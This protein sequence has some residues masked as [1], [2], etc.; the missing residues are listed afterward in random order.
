PAGVRRRIRRSPSASWLAISDALD[1]GWRGARHRK[2]RSPA[3][4]TPLAKVRQP[5]ATLQRGTPRVRPFA[6]ERETT[7]EQALD[8]ASGRLDLGGLGRR[9][10][11]GAHQPADARE[12]ARGRARGAGGRQLL[13]EPAAR[14]P[15][16]DDP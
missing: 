6:V 14:L 7:H 1:P 12:G 15:G 11:A 13:P 4:R 5:V 3:A 9:R 2:T 16:W 10:R 8:A